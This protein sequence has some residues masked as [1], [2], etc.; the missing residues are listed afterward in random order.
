M[1]GTLAVR[2]GQGIGSD[3]AVQTITWPTYNEIP[4]VFES[5]TDAGKSKKIARVF[6]Q[7]FVTKAVF[8]IGENSLKHAYYS[9]PDLRASNMSLGLSVDLSWK[10]GFQYDIEL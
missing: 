4:P 9:T 1:N 8:R 6:I 5:G 7:D 10:D 3:T 2:K